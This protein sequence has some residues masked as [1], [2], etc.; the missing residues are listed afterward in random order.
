MEWKWLFFYKNYILN[1]LCDDLYVYYSSWKTAKELYYA[2]QKKYDI[3][4]VGTKKFAVSR[5]LKFQMIDDK[6]MEAQ[7]YELLNIAHE[8]IYEGMNLDEQFQATVIINKFPPRW[9]EFKKDLQHKTNEFSLDSLITCL[10]IE[11]EVRKQDLQEA[12]CYLEYQQEVI[13]EEPCY[14]CSQT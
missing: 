5:Y 7:L 10:W 12:L 1:G 2:L 14:C 6:F 4:E 9:K 3:E 13:L 11:E 8:I